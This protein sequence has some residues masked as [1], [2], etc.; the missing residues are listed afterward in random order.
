MN[1]RQVAFVLF[2]VGS[3]LVASAVR[4]DASET[5]T[6]TVSVSAAVAT[7]T[8]L[9]VSDDVLRFDVADEATVATASVDFSAGMR[10]TS[11]SDI[12][13]TVEPIGSLE[14]PGGAADVET[15]IS[16]DG[17]G[18]GTRAGRLIAAGPSVAGRWHGSGLRQGR[19][20]FTLRAAAPGRYVVPVRFVLSTP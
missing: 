15:S 12:M 5:V 13:L 1:R 9:Q 17:V 8:S 3:S 10:I 6:A 18:D 4:T 20:Q 7:R 19:L 2:V 11:S 16:F 14:G